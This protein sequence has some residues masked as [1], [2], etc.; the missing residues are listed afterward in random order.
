MEEEKTIY[1]TCSVCKKQV[2]IMIY[3]CPNC[4]S[5][6]CLVCKVNNDWKCPNCGQKLDLA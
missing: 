2:V 3:D 4:K 5:K 6:I 1:E